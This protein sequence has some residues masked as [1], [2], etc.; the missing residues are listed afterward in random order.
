MNQRIGAR[1]DE[2][3][4]EKARKDSAL[5]IAAPINDGAP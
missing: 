5:R 3:A 2:L 4:K 1:S